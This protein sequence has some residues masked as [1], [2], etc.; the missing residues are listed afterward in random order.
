[1]KRKEYDINGSAGAAVNIPAT[2]H[3]RRME[4]TEVN[5]AAKPAQGIDYTTLDDAFADTHQLGPADTLVLGGNLQNQDNRG[6]IIGRPAQPT[7]DG[8]TEAATT[9]AKLKSSTVTATRVLVV[10]YE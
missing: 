8:K 3:C 2:I 4:I 5:S 10:E 7:G 9:V 6:P 1:V